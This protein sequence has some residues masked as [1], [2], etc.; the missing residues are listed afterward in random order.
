MPPQGFGNVIRFVKCTVPICTRHT[1]L[2]RLPRYRRN[3]CHNT[4]AES[5]KCQ[6]ALASWQVGTVTLNSVALIRSSVDP[7]LR[8]GRHLGVVTPCQWHVSSCCTGTVLSAAWSLWHFAK[9]SVALYKRDAIL[10]MHIN[11]HKTAPSSFPSPVTMLYEIVAPERR[12]SE[13]KGCETS[14]HWAQV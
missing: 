9:V 2:P 12:A 13:S 4:S 11:S 10:S 14:S 7:L 1:G 5:R 6:W 3:K 8:L